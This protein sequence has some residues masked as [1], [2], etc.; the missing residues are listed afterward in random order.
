M[1]SF[2][3]LIFCLTLF[4]CHDENR[5]LKQKVYFEK[6]YINMAWIPQS[7]GFLIDS[8]GTVRGF[9]WVEVSHIWYDPDS[10]GTVSAANMDKNLSYCQIL[11][12]HINPDTLALYIRKI[13]AAANG[14]IAAPQHVMADA[15]TTTYSAFIFDEKNNRY[16]QVLIKTTGDILTLNTAP[17]AEQIYQWMVRIGATP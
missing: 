15:G 8:T 12:S 6:H 10:T 2:I 5:V 14:I 17:E 9:S 11:N 7:T 3:I 4:A 1:K 16:K 13:P